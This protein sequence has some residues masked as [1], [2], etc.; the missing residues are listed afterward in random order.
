MGCAVD[1]DA[2]SAIAVICPDGDAFELGLDGGLGAGGVFAGRSMAGGVPAGTVLEYDLFQ[3]AA[4]TTV[5]GDT[6]A[7]DT[8]AGVGLPANAPVNFTVFGRI[9]AGQSPNPG[10]Y[11]DTV[12]AIVFF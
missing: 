6:F 8:Q 2:S 3:E 12:T 5:W 11:A 7:V 1:V 10:A 4:R 9:P